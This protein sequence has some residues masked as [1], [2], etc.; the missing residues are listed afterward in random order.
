MKI[1]ELREKTVDE[2]QHHGEGARRAA[3]RAAA[4]EG[5]RSAREPGQDPQARKRDLARVLTVLREKQSE[6]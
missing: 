3:V 1:R 5:D 2:L 6:A 4:A